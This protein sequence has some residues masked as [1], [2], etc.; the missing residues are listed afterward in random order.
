MS[1]KKFFALSIFYFVRKKEVYDL[2]KEND[3]FGQL[4]V[5]VGPHK[6]LDI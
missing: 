2:C 4:K 5:N 3:L 1:K 6:L